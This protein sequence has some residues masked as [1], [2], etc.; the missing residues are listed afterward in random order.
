[1]NYLSYLN[2]RNFRGVKNL[3]LNYLS[4]IN[5]IVGDNNSGKT[6][7]L[8]A[9]S[10]LENPDSI[11]HM[12]INASKRDSNNTSKFELFLE[13]FPKNQDE[14]KGIHINS[15]IN[16][17]ENK[18]EIKGNLND[19]IDFNENDANFDCKVFEGSVRLKQNDEEL[20]N[21]EIYIQ[22]NKRLRS[23]GSY[24]LIKIVYVTPYDHFRENVLNNT[25]EVIKDGDKDKLIK[26][27]QM[28]DENIL[29]FEVLPNR[30]MNNSSIYINHKKYKL[31]PLSSF[32][33]GVK[34]VITLASAIVSAK[35]GIL[36]IDEI[37]TAIYKD[38]VSEVFRWFVKAC[39]E[40]KVQLISTTHSLEVIDAMIEGIG[41]K[42][43]DLTCFRIESIND[44]I[45]TTR[46]SGSKLK[47]I[48]TIIGQDVR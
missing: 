35:G 12:L 21:K 17:C 30:Y 13:M 29:S 15:I 31:M 26:L 19:I 22:E 18:L 9:I 33:D 27:L 45:Y 14:N 28:F 42:L 43:D 24:N 8:E 48:R 11:R 32:G 3:E 23:S 2:I 5:I 7:L 37:E 47:D 20:I 44:N 34:K 41:N 36:L 16:K 10:L 1:M 25:I 46:F 39:I 6:S 40:Y 4:T 38:M